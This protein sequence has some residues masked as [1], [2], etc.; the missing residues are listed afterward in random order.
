VKGCLS[1][2][3]ALGLVALAVMLLALQGSAKGEARSTAVTGRLIAFERIIG[4]GFPDI[5]VMNE[6]GQGVRHVGPGCCFAWSPDGVKLAVRRDDGIHVVNVD[7]SGV[8]RLTREAGDAELRWSP[9]GRKIVFKRSGA[10]YVMSADGTAVKRLTRPRRTERDA[11]PVWSP[12]GRRIA[13]V[14][15]VETDFDEVEQLFVMNANGSG[16]HRVARNLYP[17]SVSWSPDGRR[18]ACECWNGDN[19]D[20]Y[21]L[22]ADGSQ[23]VNLTPSSGDV[24]DAE[25]VWSPDGKQ[26][27]FESKASAQADYEIHVIRADGAARRR[28]TRSRGFDGAPDWSPEGRSIVYMS[29]RDG[30]FDIYAMTATGRSQTNLTNSPKGTRN[31]APAWSPARR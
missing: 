9:D 1:K 28:L 12:D 14:R 11:A 20:I 25:P 23:Q 24:D 3:F 26:I 4:R 7:G 27:A 2:P 16:Q 13:W 6:N 21:L 19:Y 22:D 18:F 29:E 10:L 8:R 31:A 5:Y 17:Y 15:R 30:N